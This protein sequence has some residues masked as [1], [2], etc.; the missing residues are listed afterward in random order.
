MNAQEMFTLMRGVPGI[1]AFG[2]TCQSAL[3]TGYWTSSLWQQTCNGA[4]LKAQQTWI[5]SGK[6]Y[7]AIASPEYIANKFKTKFSNFRAYASPEEF[8]IDYA[9]K[10]REY[11]PRCIESADNFWGYFAG[12]RDGRWGPWAT[13]PEYFGKLCSI[14]GKLAPELLGHGWRGRMHLSYRLACDRGTLS[15]DQ[16]L[17]IQTLLKEVDENENRS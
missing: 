12:L 3:E 10:I 1:N 15:D 7:V 5:R 2:A 8:L 6:R 4:G 11:Y 14:G 16:K 9:E 17:C 13:D